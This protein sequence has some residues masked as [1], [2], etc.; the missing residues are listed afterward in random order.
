MRKLRRKCPNFEPSGIL[1][2]EDNLVN[3][4]VLK[5]NEPMDAAEPDRRWRLYVFKGEE[6]LP[7]LHIHRQSCY[8]IGRDDRVSDILLEHPSIS[9]QHAVIQYREY[10]DVDANGSMIYEVRP[11]IIDLD[12]T[13]KTML[14]TVEIEPARYYEL[15]DKDI[16][17]FGKSTRDY[18]IMTGSLLKD[19]EDD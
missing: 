2:E 11:Y 16:L 9:S 6:E 8:L 3:G 14:N 18:V 4:V 5:F 1:A 12:S 15:R 7:T 13:N 19:N 10:K 17:N